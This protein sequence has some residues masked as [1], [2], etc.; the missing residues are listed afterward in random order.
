MKRISHYTIIFIATQ[1]ILAYFLK[2]A[3]WNPGKSVYTFGG[4]GAF[5]YFNMIF[6][7]FF[8]SGFALENMNYPDFESILMTDAQASLSIVFSKIHALFPD[9]LSPEK[10]IGLAHRFHYL[11]IGLAGIYVYK[12]LDLLKIKPFF[13][14]PAAILITMLS[15][16]IIRLTAGHFGL[17][18]PFVFAFC[19]YYIIQF[20]TS[21]K[22]AIV[23]AIGLICII[24]FFGLNNFY[25]GMINLTFLLL[26]GIFMLVNPESRRK[27]LA[28]IGIVI[29][30]VLT[31]YS[32][33]HFT[34]PEFD[35]IKIQWGYYSNSVDIS[36]FLYPP[37]SLLNNLLSKFG[38][39]K[40]YGGETWVNLGLAPILII[41][42]LPIIF[43]TGKNQEKTS[44][45][46]IG[47]FKIF[48]YISIVLLLYASAIFYRI[49]F[50]KDTFFHQ[51]GIF[52]MFKASARFAWPIYFMFSFAAVYYL[53]KS[54]MLLY[55]S[56]RTL[57]IIVG[58]FIFT[59]W[60]VESF[61][62]LDKKVFTQMHGNPY[63]SPTKDGIL[64]SIVENEIDLDRYQAVYS[65]PV[66]EGWNDK[67]QIVPHFNAEF[68]SILFSMSTGMPMINAMHSRIGLTN[69]WKAIQ[70]SSHPLIYKE[71]VEDFKDLR[72]ILL[73][74]GK[75][76][77]NLSPGEQN[78][79]SI[80]DLVLDSE[81]YQLRSLDLEA[82]N[83]STT[84]DSLSSANLALGRTEFTNDSSF[85][86]QESWDQELNDHIFAGS[87][88]HKLTRDETILEREISDNP[89]GAF[90]CSVYVRIDNK[91]YGMPIFHVELYN[92]ESTK[93]KEVSFH[94]M[95]SKDVQASWARASVNIEFPEET[96]SIKIHA[97][98]INQVFYIDELN[99][100]QYSS[101]MVKINKKENEFLFNN[102]KWSIK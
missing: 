76:A 48:V 47:L 11:M 28:L 2:D 51:F 8:G 68:N 19:M 34:D 33:I 67:F 93:T 66:M 98:S 41:L 17:A 12:G 61:Y 52:S 14:I 96:R 77:E 86:I 43:L 30:L 45:Q 65:V 88:S 71:K 69:A 1:L 99:I 62:Y 49:P 53:Q 20:Y 4:D 46:T 79:L 70:L 78:L 83:N 50:M 56:K 35:R 36:S 102:Y 64:N 21:S 16:M 15:P 29:L 85:Y 74:Y 87:G 42:S 39:V 31:L 24:L 81:S 27:A 95:N 90:E 18:Y 80:S 6:H 54:L 101:E 57:A 5:I 44:M 38:S 94:S 97:R 9:F 23:P 37:T 91:M 60:S 92:G 82:L 100:R 55:Q 89:G 84:R 58:A 73:L 72:P 3:F 10:V 25:I 63:N 59:L 75:G 40:T 32:F 22:F 26:G 13:S 7:T